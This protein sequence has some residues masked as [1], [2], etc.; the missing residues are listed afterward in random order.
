MKSPK[1]VKLLICKCFKKKKR[2]N[3][4]A[5]GQNEDYRNI[6]QDKMETKD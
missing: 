3:K 5:K 4:K 1:S 2:D 6:E